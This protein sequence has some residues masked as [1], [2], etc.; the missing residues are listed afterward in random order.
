MLGKEIDDIEATAYKVLKPANPEKR[1]NE[2]PP[3]GNSDLVDWLNE[4]L[5]Q[6]H[7]RIEELK[8]LKNRIEL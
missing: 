8:E 2:P 6:I 4:V 3:T 7:N 5:Y 1:T